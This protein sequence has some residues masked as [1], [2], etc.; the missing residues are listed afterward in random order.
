MKKYPHL[1]DIFI[2]D[3]LKKIADDMEEYRIITLVAP[4]GYGKSSF[5]KK[6]E[7]KLRKKDPTAIILHQELLGESTADTWEAF[8]YT[9]REYKHLTKHLEKINFP[10]NSHELRLVAQV[11]EETWSVWDQEL[12]FVLE[13]IQFI[14]PA[15]II[16]LVKVLA[17]SLPDNVHLVLSSRNRVFSESE[18]LSLGNKLLSLTI[19]DFK[20]SEE[21]VEKYAKNCGVE[22]EKEQLALINANSEGWISLIYLQLKNYCQTGNWNEG[23][24]DATKLMEQVVFDNLPAQKRRFIIA[25]CITESFTLEQAQ[26]VWLEGNTEEILDSLTRDNSFITCNEN[27]E[28]RYHSMLKKC[29]LEHFE[30]MDDFEKNN[31]YV[32]LGEWQQSKGMFL[33]AERS[34]EKAGD[35][36]RVLTCFEK[37]GFIPYHPVAVALVGRIVYECPREILKN[38]PMAI[39]HFMQSLYIAMKIPEVKFLGE[40]LFESIRDNKELDED[41]RNNILGERELMMAFLAYNDVTAMNT[42]QRK[43]M[44]LMTRTSKIINRMAPWTFGN[45]SVLGMYHKAIGNL[46]NEV[47]AMK[48]GITAYSQLTDGH[49]NGAEYLIRGEAAYYEGNMMDAEVNYHIAVAAAKRKQ[50]NSIILAAEFLYSRLCFYRGDYDSLVKCYNRVKSTLNEYRLY[51]LATAYE[52]GYAWIMA[53]MGQTDQIP[54]W[55]FDEN[56]QRYVMFHALPQFYVVRNQCWIAKKEWARIIAAEHELGPYFEKCNVVMNRIYLHFQLATAYEKMG[57]HRAACREARIAADI[58]TPDKIMMPSIEVDDCISDIMKDVYVHGEFKEIETI[59]IGAVINYR[60]SKEKIISCY[61]KK[62]DDYNLTEREMEIAKLAAGRL[63]NKEIAEEL[64]LSDYTVKN[65]LKNIFDK[66]GIKGTD[67][68]KRILLAEKI[69]LLK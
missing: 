25:N 42:C 54:E 11:I 14:E 35:Y 51:G 5:L 17:S 39:L 4:M 69:N 65:H 40:F 30:T 41:T 8:C 15:V 21:D 10:T 34:F 48:E 29:A 66:V 57:N 49:G 27:G 44:T 68:N 26:V 3:H 36:E 62:G 13:N 43:A 23:T 67:K 53:L 2:T 22:L 56:A 7:Q 45:L 19:D 12:Y 52:M 47:N 1:N 50:Q 20:L 16:P 59:V 33:D 18:L 9:L 37:S 32:R 24:I 63:T 28:Y 61:E 60:N 46:Q 38:H 64:H 55:I 58:A 31:L 6:W